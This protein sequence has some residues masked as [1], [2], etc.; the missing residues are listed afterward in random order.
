VSGPAAPAAVTEARPGSA[1]ARRAMGGLGAISG[2]PAPTTVTEARPGSAGAR[3]AMG[4]LGAISGPP[5]PTT[6]TEARPGSA[7]ARRAMGGLGA[8]SGPPAPATVT[9]ARPGSAGGDERWGFGAISG[10]PAPA[11][12]TE[13]RPG[14]AAARRA[15]GGWGPSRGPHVNRQHARSCR[16]CVRRSPVAV[17]RKLSIY[18]SRASGTSAALSLDRGDAPAWGGTVDHNRP[19]GAKPAP[20]RHR[21]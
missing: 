21:R 14:A 20:D 2:P 10:P 4:G 19:A 18:R 12:V 3:R 7:G 11:T 1:G 17:I 9:E 13:A 6:V 15:M 5:A 16:A 8:I